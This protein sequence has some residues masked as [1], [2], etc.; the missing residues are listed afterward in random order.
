MLPS[1]QGMAGR[2]SHTHTCPFFSRLF[3]EA[4]DFKGL[5]GGWRPHA[6]R[7]VLSFQSTLYDLV[8]PFGV[9]VAF[10]AGLPC[11]QDG[12]AVPCGV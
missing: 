3:P 10:P 12:P 11:G 8:L 9:G 6:S 7:S 5:W 1:F 4:W 2:V